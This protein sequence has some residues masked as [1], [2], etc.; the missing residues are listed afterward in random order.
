M[1]RRSRS[2]GRCTASI[3]PYQGSCPVARY[4]FHDDGT[5]AR[6]EDSSAARLAR[7]RFPGGL[8]ESDFPAAP[9]LSQRDRRS[10]RPFHP[11][12]EEGPRDY[13]RAQSDRGVL[14]T[15]TRSNEGGYRCMELEM[16]V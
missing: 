1:R 16:L 4:L 7:P 11:G 8:A 13:I 5:G 14:H 9:D 12:N 3:D 15:L 6:S 10:V 2:T